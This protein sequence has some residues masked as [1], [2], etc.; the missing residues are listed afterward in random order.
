MFL[1]LEDNDWNSTLNFSV[2]TQRNA[3]QSKRHLFF[4]KLTHPSPAGMQNP[5]A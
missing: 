5:S 3:I 2:S 4:Y 1:S